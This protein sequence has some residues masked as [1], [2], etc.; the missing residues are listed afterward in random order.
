MT[1]TRN[2]LFACAALVGAWGLASQA[3]AA[4]APALSGQV[5]LDAGLVQGTASAS[6]AAYLGLPFAAPP[7]GAL[8]WKAPAPV[9]PWQGT[10]PA[11][12]AG[13]A[14]KQDGTLPPA[15][16]PDSDE[17]CL[18]LN[19]YVPPQATD[20]SKLPVMVWIHGG[21]FLNGA[22][23]QYNGSELAKVADAVV[24]T[25]NYRLG[26][27]GFMALDALSAE[28]PAGN[29][30]LQDQQAALRWV[31]R[32]IAGFG[33]D[34]SR[35][36][37]FGESAGG[38]SVCQQVMSPGAAGLFHRAI[39]QSG[40][41]TYGTATRE[42]AVA[43]GNAVAQKL[44]CAP[45]AG[46][47]ACLRSKSADE[48]FSV[49]PTIDFDDLRSLKAL[50]PWV[51]GVVLPAQP[52]QLLKQGKFNRV[53]VMIGSNQNEGRL[54]IALAFDMHRGAPLT[55]A[56]YQALVKG[57]AGND[58]AASL[59][60]LD[61]SS[62]RLGSPNLAAAALVTDST[63]SCGTQYT[64]RGFAAHVP[65]YA[66]EFQEQN[67]PQ[68]AADPFMPWGAYHAAELPFLFMSSISTTPASPDPREVATP[69][70]LS[71]SV[72]MVG[73]WGRFAA[74]GNPNGWNAP[75]WPRFGGLTAAT[76]LLKTPRITTDKLGGIYSQ[77]QCLLWDA[78]SSLGLG[79]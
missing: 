37:I 32:N 6:G 64:A 12:Q 49:A 21:A 46:Q 3:M 39:I 31:Q 34:T 23:S 26:I 43:K 50:T 36:T 61:Y 47:L 77:H 70:Q 27:F 30:G 72:Q 63:F 28:A 13:H 58:F 66:Y 62:K 79:L 33:G 54:F 57:I 48:V 52:K 68:L 8:R 65:T 56:G 69:E 51:D 2:T 55:E 18:Y 1:T 17:D 20:T 25:V 45:G 73:Y 67:V 24:V 29:Q 15:G 71:L 14:C 78:A 60:T 22:G 9:T 7:V 53:P 75:E 42:E 41:C 76:Q 4:P 38:A 40:P 44:G 74:T 16:V 19:V 10:R 5:R 59:V 11:T 35:V